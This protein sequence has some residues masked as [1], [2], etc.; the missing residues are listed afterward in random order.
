MGPS[1][2]C[3]ELT[4]NTLLDQQK[5]VLGAEN[6][7]PPCRFQFTDR[8]AAFAVPVVEMIYAHTHCGGKKV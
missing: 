3:L 1:S 2:D 5:C 7:T 8:G 4:E 6:R